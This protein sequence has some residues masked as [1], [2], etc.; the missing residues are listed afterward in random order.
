M[1]IK[2]IIENSNINIDKKNIYYNE[3][4]SKYTSFKIGGEAEC[5]IK[6]FNYDELIEV[7]RIV[8]KNNIKITVLGNGTNCLV[9]D[10]GIKGITLM[11]RFEEISFENEDRNDI[12]CIVDSGCKIGKLAQILLKKEITGFEELSGIPRNNRWSN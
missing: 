10:G 9:L 5:L 7:L 12:D 3:P 4:M 11:I 2:D 6:V 1:P 8:K